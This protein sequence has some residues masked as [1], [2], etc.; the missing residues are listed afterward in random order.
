MYPDVPQSNAFI[1]NYLR[2][3]LMLRAGCYDQ[4]LADCRGFFSG[5]AKLT[6]TLWEHARV[7]CSLNHGFASLAAYYIDTALKNGG[8]G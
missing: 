7:T 6:G 8:K 3:E 4:V 2:L 5:M 1:G